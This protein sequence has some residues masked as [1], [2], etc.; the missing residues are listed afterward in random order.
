MV[1]SNMHSFQI[2]IQYMVQLV[3]N[4]STKTKQKFFNNNFESNSILNKKKIKLV[5]EEEKCQ[6]E[7]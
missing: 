6:Y 5:F 3:Y 4:M 2:I 1:M 7:L